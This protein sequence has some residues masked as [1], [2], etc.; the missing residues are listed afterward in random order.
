M[1]I[2]ELRQ[3]IS[4]LSRQERE[5]LAE[6]IL[7]SPDSETRVAE[8]LLTYG[9]QQRLS[10]EEYLR[11]EDESDRRH[12]YI[13][14]QIFEVNRPMLRHHLIVGNVVGYL[15]E[16]LRS[17]QCKVFSSNV[18]VRL[19]VA[20]CDIVY[21][22]DV[23]VACG[24]FTQEALDLQYLTEPTV[25]IEV[26]SPATED[27]DRREKLLNYRQIPSLE[28]Y[29]LVAQWSP[30]VTVY[31]RSDNWNPLVLREPRDVFESSAMEVSITLADIYE[32]LR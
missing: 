25:A 32:G 21:I 22:P 11:L 23:V 13:D 18:R 17:S 12:E 29:V 26:F 7:N 5:D 9:A 1:T 4:Q 2:S 28:E 16:Q 30:R 15:Y 19:R 20:Q 31:R 10:V 3:A 27:I 14:G 8:R 24:P 6:W